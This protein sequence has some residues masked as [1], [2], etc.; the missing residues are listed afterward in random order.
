M[1]L[2]PRTVMIL[3]IVGATLMGGALFV[4]TRGSLGQVRGGSRWARATLIQAAGW[5]LIGPLRSV[6]PDLIWVVVGYGLLSLSLALYL[7]AVAEFTNQPI[8]PFW[9]YGM[10]VMQSV[11]LTFLVATGQAG[12]ARTAVAGAFAGVLMLKS[13]HLLFAGS[14]SRRASHALTATLFALC[15]VM[16][17]ARSI[18]EFLLV[19]DKGLTTPPLTGTVDDVT[20]LMFYVT[21]TLLTFGFVLMLVD[22][23]IV[24]QQRAETEVKERASLSSKA[25]RVARLGS[26][27]F[28]FASGSWASSPQLDDLCGIDESYPRNRDTWLPLIAP[29][30]REEIGGL[31]SGP[32]LLRHPRFRKECRIIRHS[33]QQER[34]VIAF[35]ELEL[36]DRQEPVR[37]IGT[38]QDITEGKRLE[39]E[40]ENESRLLELIARGGPLPGML[41]ELLLGY[42]RLFPGLR[43]SV[44]LMDPDGRHLRHLAAPHLPPAYCQAIDGVEIGPGVGSC[45]TA[46]YTGKTTMVADV[47]SD[48]LWRDYK[49]L[50]LGHGLRACWSVP[51]LGARDGVLGTFAFYANAPRAALSTELAS[52]ERGAH[53]ASLAIEK[54][55]AEEALRK[56]K[57][58]LQFVMDHVPARIFWKDGDLRYVGANRRFAIDAGYHDPDQ[59]IGKTD[60]EMRWAELAEVY[61]TGD[62][63]VM[64][65]GLPKLDC[66]QPGTTPDGQQVWLSTSKVPLRDEQNHVAGILGIDQD[67][68]D[69]KRA[70]KAVLASLSEKEALLKEVHHRVK[71]NLALITS[72]MRLETGKSREPE[73]KSALKAMQA[74][75]HS[76]MLLNETLY[77]TQ[78]YSQVKLADYLRQMA[79]HLFRAQNPDPD[80]VR[81]VLD[82]E[83]V[84]VQTDQAIPCG[85]IVNELMTN[86]LKYAFAGGKRGEVRV[87]LSQE[88]YGPA[89]LRVSDTGVGLPADF[90]ARRG[91]SLGLQLVGD[92]AKQLQG[93]LEVG[94]GPTFTVTFMR[95]LDRGTIEIPPLS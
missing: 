29:D 80:A 90:E 10:L 6:A 18:S 16:M 1:N 76:V 26:Y 72:L 32:T 34:W 87:S 48:P 94:P 27:K 67:I 42:E 85:L 86:S 2:D 35:G 45:G 77:K 89:R 71:N 56:S 78:H 74:R 47:A 46:A 95:R 66:E 11:A 52:L 69:R 39:A 62:R 54:Q 33:D 23:Y 37:L 15:G 13:G 55:R 79:T 93:A 88:P 65:S 58:M 22:R 40:K 41:A 36:D 75:I 57:D 21:A 84:E 24:Q 5:T 49:D 4:I 9:V 7:T 70:E 8:R 38:L 68:T 60:F 44:L 43:G 19:A 30:L 63:A 12:A 25:Q 81:L 50:A 14:E 61:R 20:Y 83:P 73:T 64:E 92:L 82:L 53:L 28:E 3:I 31:M 51:I 17:V 91:G 59:L